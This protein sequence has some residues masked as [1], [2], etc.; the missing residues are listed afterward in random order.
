M[1]QQV[2]NIGALAN[3]GTGDPLRDAFDKTNDN[4]AELYAF[5]GDFN[6]YEPAIDDILVWDG[7]AFVNVPGG[8]AGLLDVDTDG[9]LAANSDALIPTQKAVKTYV[10]SAVTGLLDLKGDTDCSANPNYPAALKGDA[11]YVTV[12]GK[13]GGASGKSVDVGDTY[14][15]KADNAGGDEAAVGA[16]WFILEHNLS[17]VAL[18]SGATFTGAVA[19]PDDAYDAT[20]WNASANVPTKNAIRDKFEALIAGLPSTYTDEQVRDVVMAMISGT[21]LL[22]ETENDGA[23]TDTLTV[24][25]SSTTDVLTG[26][27]T[28]S[29][30]TPDALAAL[31]EKGADVASAATVTLG[32]G[33]LF[34]ITGSTGPITD[35]DPGTDKAGR[36]FILVFDST[37][38]L[39]HNGSTLVLPTGANIVAAAGDSALFVSEGTD[40]VR[41][42]A[43]NRASG[44]ALASSGSYIAQ[45]THTIPLLAGA[46]TARTTNGAASGTTESSS[47]KVMLRT[48][49]FDTTTTEYVQIMIP[50]PKSWNEGTI[51][52]QFIWA[53][54]GGTGNVVWACR[55]VAISD[56]DVIDAAFGTAQTVTDGVTA[57]TDVME[58]AF[59][60]AITIAGTPAAEDL[61]CFEFY[62]DTGDG[63]DTLAS[64]AKLIAVRLNYTINAADDS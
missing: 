41:C 44:A 32:E 46:M 6:Y 21:G 37:P 30:V 62:R 3:D 55:A 61:V 9:T 43:Y 53:G 31:W 28:T 34:H 58:S 59:T 56:D 47:N 7:V 63:A 24:T 26:T 1:T 40:A 54:P 29:A 33:G 48:F 15:A 36:Y 23:D 11:Y 25:A 4:F 50:M 22:V 2:I 35:I 12:A 39:T 10:A 20:T 45:G 5:N 8:T 16:S 38:T 42:V 18:L 14:I 17:G 57:T 19:V 52:A 13:I 27:S 64:D 51:T 49:D 60:S